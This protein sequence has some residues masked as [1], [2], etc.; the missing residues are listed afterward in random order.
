MERCIGEKVAVAVAEA[1]Q[2][3][4]HASRFKYSRILNDWMIAVWFA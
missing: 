1:V 3:A 2:Q 4:V